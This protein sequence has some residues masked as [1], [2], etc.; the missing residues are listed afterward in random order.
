MVVM[1]LLLSPWR[2]WGGLNVVMG[3]RARRRPLASH[4]CAHM[5]HLLGARHRAMCWG[6]SDGWILHPRLLSSWILPLGSDHCP[7]TASDTLISLVW[8][9]FRN[10]DFSKLPG[11]PTVQVES[12]ARQG[13]IILLTHMEM[14]TQRGEATHPRPHSQESKHGVG[15]DPGNLPQVPKLV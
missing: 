1:I 11:N 6:D 14:E 3:V 8:V 13:R 5:E 2:L 15:S 10:Q 9:G 4:T 7:A 12:P